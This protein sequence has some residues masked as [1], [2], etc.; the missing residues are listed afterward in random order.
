[1]AEAQ[2][3][4]LYLVVV[5][6]QLEA[7][8]WHH[9]L[10][11]G[12]KFCSIISCFSISL[13]TFPIKSFRS[14]PPIWWLYTYTTSGHAISFST[15]SA[16]CDWFHYTVR[17]HQWHHP[18]VVPPNYTNCNAITKCWLLCQSSYTTLFNFLSGNLACDLHAQ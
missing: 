17:G 3:C 10:T 11:C 13:R 15:F 16:F 9:N 14:M 18:T 7:K 6:S 2:L 4:H 5:I 1:M 12:R 8:C